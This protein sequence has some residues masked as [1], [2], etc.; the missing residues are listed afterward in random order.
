MTMKWDWWQDK[1]KKKGAADD[2]EVELMMIRGNREGAP[3]DSEVRL[4]TIRKDEK[5][6]QITRAG[7]WSGIDDD[8]RDE[9][10][11]H[12]DYEEALMMVDVL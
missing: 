6:W 9:E 4:M 8:R 12:D 7:R 11:A 3:D 2:N 1:G 10:E 5:G